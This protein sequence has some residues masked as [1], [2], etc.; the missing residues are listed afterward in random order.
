MDSHLLQDW[1]TIA[2]QSGDAGYTITQSE[3]QWLDLEPYDDVIFYTD[4]RQLTATPM[5]TFQTAPAPEEAAFQAIV[6]T[7]TLAVSSSPVVSPALA[8]YASVP[9]ARYVRWKLSAT[10]GVFTATFRIWVV[11][12]SPGA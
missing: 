3:S 12:F 1:I 11:A 2:G 10:G 8:A 9:L 4:V 6:P 5:I 7:I